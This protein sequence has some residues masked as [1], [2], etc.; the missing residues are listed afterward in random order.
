MNFCLL[1]RIIMKSKGFNKG[2]NF[3]L[4]GKGW[5][6]VQCRSATV[7]KKRD[8][9]KE[10]ECRSFQLSIPIPFKGKGK[11]LY[12]YFFKKKGI[13][14]LTK[15]IT[16][17]RLINMCAKSERI[18][19]DKKCCSGNQMKLWNT[20]YLSLRKFKWKERQGSKSEQP[21]PATTVRFEG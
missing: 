19:A 6:T 14:G 15:I 13:S 5:Q 8:L 20:K 2:K 18:T 10:K 3:F 16:E 1:S 4:D 11:F 21:Q 7:Q 9:A 17:W 12:P